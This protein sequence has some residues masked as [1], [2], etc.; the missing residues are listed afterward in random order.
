[1]KKSKEKKNFS[2][3]DEFNKSLQYT[4]VTTWVIL[5]TAIMALSALFAWASIYKIKEKITGKAVISS[6]EVTLDVKESQKSRLAVGQKVYI[7]DKVG[8]ILSFNDGD[9]V[10]SSFDLADNEYTYTVVI[11]EF[12]PIDF[13]IK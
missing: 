2:N 3:P 9:P 6:G 13:L 11:N 5:G 10:I 7:A 1:M 12:R 8:Q 4:S